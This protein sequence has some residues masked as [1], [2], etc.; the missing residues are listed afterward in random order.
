MNLI[1]FL[2]IYLRIVSIVLAFRKFRYFI[3]VRGVVLGIDMNLFHSG[4]DEQCEEE[5]RLH[6]GDNRQFDLMRLFCS[7]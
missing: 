2:A 1:V 6:N 7:C 3:Y 5:E 4:H